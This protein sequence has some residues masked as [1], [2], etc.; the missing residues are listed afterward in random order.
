MITDVAMPGSKSGIDLAKIVSKLWPATLVI[1]LSGQR[2]PAKA[3][4]SPSI[5]FLQK[6][7]K[8]SE[9]LARVTNP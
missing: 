6:P 4:L 8:D 9:L 2:P 5:K 1:V 7:C 3:T